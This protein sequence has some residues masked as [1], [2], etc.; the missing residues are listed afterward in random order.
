MNQVRGSLLSHY[1]PLRQ[2]QKHKT[3]NI[4]SS[5]I[6]FQRLSFILCWEWFGHVYLCCVLRPM[7]QPVAQGHS[8]W[9]GLQ[10]HREVFPEINGRAEPKMKER[11]PSGMLI[12]Q[13]FTCW[14][15]IAIT[16]CIWQTQLD[17][18]SEKLCIWSWIILDPYNF[19]FYCL[20]CH[21][22]LC[23][24]SLCFSLYFLEKVIIFIKKV[25]Q[26]KIILN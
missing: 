23:Q 26:L 16:V 9:T 4:V 20:S 15:I 6:H 8:T 24:W 18:C 2:G 1:H 12:F 21:H 7:S 19:L 3:K 5:H 14:L 10:D 17:M 25:T 11:A 22:S 13:G